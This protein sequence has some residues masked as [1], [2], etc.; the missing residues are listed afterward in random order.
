MPTLVQGDF[1]WDEQKAESNATK[2][3]VTFDEAALAMIDPL[4][5]DFEDLVEPE[6][7]D[8]LGSLSN[9]AYPLHCVHSSRRSDSPHQCSPG[10]TE[11]AK[12][13]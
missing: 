2:H 10:N 12:T 8:H 6:K 4:S 1:E 3:G 9:R 5:L 11:R 13:I 7:F